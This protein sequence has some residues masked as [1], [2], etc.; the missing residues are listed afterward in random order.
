MVKVNALKLDLSKNGIKLKLP[1]FVANLSLL[2]CRVVGEQGAVIEERFDH[3]AGIVHHGC[4]QTQLDP[5][6]ILAEI[7]TVD[8]FFCFGEKAFGCF[9][10]FEGYFFAEFFLD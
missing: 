2:G 3:Q 10:F 1:G 5:F 4:S 9:V 6:E 8:T 7:A